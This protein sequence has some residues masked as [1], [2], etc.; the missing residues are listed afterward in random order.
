MVKIKNDL[1]VYVEGGGSGSSSNALHA[2]FRQAFSEF[3]KAADLEN[4]RP[5]IVPCGGREKAFDMFCTAKI[6]GKNAMLLVDS[7]GP[8]HSWNPSQTSRQWKPWSHLKNWIAPEGATDEDCHLMVE[9]MENWFLADWASVRDFF[10]R[11]FRFNVLPQSA[12]ETIS[13]SSVMEVL[14]TATSDCPNKTYNKGAHSFKLLKC[15]DPK[16]VEA[17]SPWAKRFLDELRKRKS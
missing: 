3:F 7:E 13:K 4:Q 10:G 11:N 1:Y 14:K 5:R 12:V 15:I 8:V 2:E 6:Q 17:A 16:K 9:C